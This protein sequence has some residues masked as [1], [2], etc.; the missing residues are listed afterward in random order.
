MSFRPKRAAGMGGVLL[1]V[2]FLGCSDDAATTGATT[3]AG[4]AGGA[5]GADKLDATD[6]LEPSQYDCTAGVPTPPS[7]PH[8]L[9]CVFDGTCISD[10][11]CA[12]RMGNPF[13][14][15]NSLSA[16]RAS[17]LLG[18]D[19]V[20]TDVRMTSDGHVV[21]LHDREIDRTLQGTGNVDDFTLAELKAMPVK[22][23]ETDPPGD[24]SC[25]RIV[26]LEEVMAL[27][28][29][30]IV[31]EL[32]T[33]E[34]PAGIAAATYLVDQGLE[35]DAYVQCAP[36]ECDAIRAAVPTV[37][38]MVRIQSLDDIT[39]AEAYDPP[40]ILLE[41][42]QSPTFTDPATLARIH[43]IP[44]KVFSNAFVSADAAAL[45]AGDLSGYP[46][47]YE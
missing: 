47:G 26:T 10:F 11:V 20:E 16:V 13:A 35:G 32:E 24:F 6:F 28:K 27:A 46:L 9:A 3:G 31:V 15:E 23:E 12:H 22:L 18:V 4:G 8:D 19:V 41:V 17:I 2:M 14:P 30:R 40:P 45:I 44:A 38:I 42:D 37:P 25:E 5:G 7:R 36:D 39:R 1:A 21:L 43:A 34:T 29:G 33:K